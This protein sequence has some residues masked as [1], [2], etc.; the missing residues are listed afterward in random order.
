MKSQFKE[1]LLGIKYFNKI[2]F[3]FT[4]PNADPGNREIILMIKNFVKKNANTFYVSSLGQDQF[5]SCVKYSD[6]I[7]GNS[8]SGI[9]ELPGFKKGTINIGN[10]QEGRIRSDSII[11]TACK[12]KNIILSIKKLYSQKFQKILKIS[13]NP[14]EKKNTRK[15]IVSIIKKK[16][17][18][19]IDIN[20]EFFDIN[21]KV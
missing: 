8:S 20:K 11:D 10:R 14:F 13:R 17:V 6:G 3:I 12:K 15:L 9:I 4:S 1:L 2:N 5:I 18:H 19:G 7:L 21:F 16:L